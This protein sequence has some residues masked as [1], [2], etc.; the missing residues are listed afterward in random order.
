MLVKIEEFVLYW[1]IDEKKK[2]IT[3]VIILFG[4]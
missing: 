4:K 2:V 1:L 3:C